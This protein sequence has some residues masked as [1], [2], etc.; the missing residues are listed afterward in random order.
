MGTNISA[1]KNMR[2][3]LG[4]TAKFIYFFEPEYLCGHDEGFF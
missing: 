3:R 1:N 4:N 2:V